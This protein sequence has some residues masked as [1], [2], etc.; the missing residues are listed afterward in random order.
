MPSLDNYQPDP[1]YGCHIW[2][3]N[4]SGGYGWRWVGKGRRA[5]VHREAWI[6]ANGPIPEGMELDHMCRRRLCVRPEHLELVTQ[7][8]NKR[9]MQHKHRVTREACPAGHSLFQHGRRT[10][11]GGK[12]CLVCAP[13]E[14]R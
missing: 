8:E 7:R 1:I 12:V 5:W 10:P 13:L 14:K 2:L 3:G 9:R 4:V 11:E 6:E